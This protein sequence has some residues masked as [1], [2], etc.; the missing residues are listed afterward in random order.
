MCDD[1]G[2]VVVAGEALIDL[3]VA[4]AGVTA[5]PGGA[6][7]NV[8]RACARLG[9]P[10]ALVTSLSDDGFG[11]LLEA[12]LTGAG[13]DASLVQRTDRPSTLAVAQLDAAGVAT[14]GF[15]TEGTSAPL[16]QPGPLPAA[17]TTLVTGG[18]ALVLEPMA[19][20]VERLVLDT[21]GTALV[22]VD[23]NSRPGAIGDRQTYDDRLRRVMAAAD[24]VKVS[25]EDIEFVFQDAS[26]EAAAAEVLWSGARAVLVTAGNGATTVVT[27][28]GTQSIPVAAVDV[29]DTVGA[30]DAF[31]AGFVTWWAAQELPRGALDDLAAIGAAAAAGHAVAAIVVTRRGADP[32]ARDEL[33]ACWSSA[34][35]PQGRLSG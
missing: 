27:A 29:V 1:D 3:V 5:A 8:A 21:A 22:V 10:T 9:A 16:L 15:Y 24:V 30:G 31:T 34:P 20:A 23:V 6:P 35:P 26:I 17:A 19:G 14:Y 32:P 25:E 4:P 28:E 7:Y 2:V 11:R 13:V 33:P 12:E 18:L